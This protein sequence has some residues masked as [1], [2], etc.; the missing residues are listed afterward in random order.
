MGAVAGIE[1]YTAKQVTAITGVPYQ[2]LNL[3]AR[4]GLIKPSIAQASG[5]GSERV[6]SF[7]DLIAL[8]VAMELRRSG[9]TTKALGKIVQFLR[10][11]SGLET[12][13]AE[14][15]L[16]VTGND[17][18]LVRSNEE[19][20]STLQRPGQAY[21]SFV[22]DLPKTVVELKEAALRLSVSALARSGQGRA[23]FAQR[24]EPL[25]A[26]PGA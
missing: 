25:T 1:G 14:A 21:L 7:R 22:L 6:Y 23:P 2:T 5:T 19:L 20:V 13:L 26:R 16:V 9:V 8:R 15:R 12:P 10:K 18:L 11:S 24:S 3:W 4:T 17:V